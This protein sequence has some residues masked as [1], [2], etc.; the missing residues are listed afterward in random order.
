MKLLHNIPILKSFL[1][2]TSLKKSPASLETREIY[3]QEE[4]KKNILN[5]TV[6]RGASD[7]SGFLLER[8][9]LLDTLKYDACSMSRLHKHA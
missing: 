1:T 4:L 2:E 9:L 6:S 5:A 3:F 7:T 8:G